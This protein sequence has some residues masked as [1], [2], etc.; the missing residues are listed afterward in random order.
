MKT[1][2][3]LLVSTLIGAM[4]FAEGVFAA[5][6]RDVPDSTLLETSVARI[7]QPSG[8]FTVSV[9]TCSSGNELYSIFGHSAVRVI[10]NEKGS[11]YVFNYGVFHFQNN[12]NFYLTFVRGELDYWLGIQSIEGFV[13]EYD[14]D[15]RNVYEQVLNMPE[16]VINQL[17]EKLFYTSQPEHRSYRY[18]F[19]SRNCTTEIRNLLEPY[20]K[21]ENGWLNEK[22]GHTFR[23]YLNDALKNSPWYR[24]GI[25]MILGSNIDEEMTFLESMFLPEKLFDVLISVNY[26]GKPL[27]G[28][29]QKINSAE[30]GDLSRNFIMGNAPFLLFLILFLVVIL[31]KKRTLD[32][33]YMLLIGLISLPLLFI[34]LFG[35]HVEVASNFNII[36][37]NPVLL[38]YSWGLFRR[39]AKLVKLLSYWVIISALIISIIWLIGH[40]GFDNAFVV[41]LLTLIYISLRYAIFKPIKINEDNYYRR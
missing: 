2:I 9:L 27:V 23:D 29:T 41:I 8:R 37:C 15:N 35:G 30:Q 31:V 38:L 5:A 39:K 28:K 6:T 12:L 3:K 17:V 19:I 7:E 25:D 20:I 40:Q 13:A 14:N 24:F 32:A 10:D 18:K 33:V 21:D 1:I 26:E 34:N 16:E 36:W 4:L 22:T 11:E